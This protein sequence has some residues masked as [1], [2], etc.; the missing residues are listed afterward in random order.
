M[1]D[2][3]IEESDG[4]E[5][6]IN[7]EIIYA[8]SDLDEICEKYDISNKKE[9]DINNNTLRDLI[10]LEG[11]ARQMKIEDNKILHIDYYV[12]YKDVEIKG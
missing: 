2:I 7:G 1:R 8:T 12:D 5:K 11:F 6:P 9:V 3:W 10:E 4:S